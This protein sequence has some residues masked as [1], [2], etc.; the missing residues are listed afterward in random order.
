M[1]AA[2]IATVLFAAAM[3]GGCGSSNPGAERSAKA[4]AGLRETRD[5]LVASRAQIDKTQAALDRLQ[6]APGDRRLEFDA[7][8]EQ[9]KATEGQAK[10]IAERTADMQ[11]RGAE[12]QQKWAADASQLS[13]PSLKATVQQR[14]AKVRGRYVIIGAKG[15]AARAAYQPYIRDLQDVQT[16]LS[17]DLSP[18]A[19][20]AAGPVFQKAR[21]DGQVLKQKLD[22][23]SAELDTVAT[24]LS[25]G[26]PPK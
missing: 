4:V 19:V 18:A 26:A 13:D 12:Y 6:T 7:Y 8:K 22:D 25:S 10:S 5:E 14:A 17:G 23:L 15:Q 1:F 21:S 16:F 20:Q 9:V 2:G 11:S 3:V 24:E